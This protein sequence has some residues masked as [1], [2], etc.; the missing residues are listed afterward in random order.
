MPSEGFYPDVPESTYHSDPGSL[1]V[2]G[3]KLLLKAPALFR[4][5]Q[6]HPEHKDAFDV[7]TAFHTKTLGVGP[8]IMVVNASS[9]RTKAAAEE[10]HQAREAGMTPLLREDDERTTGM[11]EAVHDNA[12]AMR[13]LT[14]QYEVSAYAPDE[15]TG[16]TRRG[17]FDCLGDLFIGDLKSTRDASPDA[18]AKDATAFR[19]YMQAA[20]YLDLAAD[21]GHPA[22]GFAFVAVEKEPPYFVAVYELDDD[23]LALGRRA[24]RRALDLYADCLRNDTWP[25]YSHGQPYQT[26]SLPP[27]AFRED[28]A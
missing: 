9:W 13:W 19:Y 7:G 16:V 22:L 28:A 24:N 27:W 8:E 18:F 11:A 12:E 2:S 15:P 25:G 3:A 20:W 6:D 21:L 17:R 5:R 10:R 23:A 26:I 14:G 1:S 4:W